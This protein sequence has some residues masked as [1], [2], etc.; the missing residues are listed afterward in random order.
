MVNILNLLLNMTAIL[1]DDRYTETSNEIECPICYQPIKDADLCILPCNHKYHT[2]CLHQSFV[3][4]GKSKCCPY[5][6]TSYKHSDENH[7]LPTSQKEQKSI[8]IML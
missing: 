8:T 3:N 4:S 2:L 5:C 6:R 1:E 7:Q